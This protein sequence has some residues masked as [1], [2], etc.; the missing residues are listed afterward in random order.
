MIAT[1]QSERHLGIGR[2]MKNAA[3]PVFDHGYLPKLGQSPGVLPADGIHIEYVA[4]AS[5]PSE[6][7][8]GWQVRARVHQVIAPERKYAVTLSVDGAR[9]HGT[10]RVEDRKSV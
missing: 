8:F 3:A 10:L 1:A 4:P 9:A 5:C 2:P 6:A 7:V